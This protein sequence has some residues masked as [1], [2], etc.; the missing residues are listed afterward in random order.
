GLSWVEDPS[1]ADTRHSRNYLRHRVVPQLT[2]RWPQAVA[3][4]ARSAEHLGEAQG[5][6][7]EL[8]AL[9]LGAARTP[10]AFPWLRLPSLGLAPLLGLSTAR[11][12]NALRHWLAPL[13]P[14]PD[15]DHWAGWETLRDAAVAALPIWRLAQGELQ[16][17]DGRLWW[18][19]DDWLQV[20]TRPLPWADSRQPLSLPGNG[21]LQVQGEGPAGEL[22]VGYRQGG[23][24]LAVPG[25]GHRDLKRLLNE[26]GLPAFARGRLPLLY[27]GDELLAVANLP[28]LN[29]PANGRWRLIWQPP[30]NDQS[31]S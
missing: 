15:S 25:R 22:R 24:V 9:D 23:E 29:G 30:T 21:R 19:A 10:S 11:Q 17:A 8:A 27:R 18:L 3:N 5:L 6:L 12:R 13:T 31:L 28:G 26:A 1:N 20:P 7:D 16:R 2:A 4:M 14:L